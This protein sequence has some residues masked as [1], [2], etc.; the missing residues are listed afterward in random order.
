MKTHRIKLKQMAYA[1]GVA[2]LS[3]IQPG[4]AQGDITTGLSTG[5]SQLV[6]YFDPITTLCMAVGAIVGIA[7]GIRVYGKW[8]NGDQDINKELLGWGGSAVFLILAPLILK[9]VFGI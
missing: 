9:G 1:L 8:N 5:T 7:G 6:S 4:F 2:M 3:G